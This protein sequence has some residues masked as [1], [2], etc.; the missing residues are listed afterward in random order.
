MFYQDW[1][2]IIHT[3]LRQAGLHWRLS[4][5]EKDLSVYF[6]NSPKDSIYLESLQ[7]HKR[8]VN[9]KCAMVAL[10]HYGLVLSQNPREGGLVCTAI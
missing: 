4:P 7:K 6:L 10:E 1:G 5:T 2:P 9:S 3:S 8:E